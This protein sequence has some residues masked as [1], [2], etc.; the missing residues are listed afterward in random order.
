MG[1]ETTPDVEE[2]TEP[3]ICPYT[4]PISHEAPTA[5]NVEP[6]DPKEKPA[7]PLPTHSLPV[8]P[9][10]RTS[11]ESTE[12]T[13]DRLKNSH[14]LEPSQLIKFLQT[15]L[16]FVATILCLLFENDFPIDA[17]SPCFFEVMEFPAPTQNCALSA[18]VQ[19]QS[20]KSRTSPSG[21]YC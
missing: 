21:G 13:E 19:M 15:D 2:S 9:E 11:T 20:A 1:I 7:T 8:H 3:P 14:L 16:Q 5:L 6:C 12:R 17:F 4:E 10:Q 18:T